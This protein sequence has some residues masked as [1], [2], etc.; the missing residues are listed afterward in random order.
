MLQRAFYQAGYHVVCLTSPTHPNFIASAST[1]GI[2]GHLL[3]DSRNLYQVMSLVWLELQQEEIEV[4]NFFLTGYSLGA[5][6]SAFVSHIDENRRVFNFKK[7]LMINPPVN[8]Y[9]SAL[10]L[11]AMLAK[12]L[13]GGM[14]NVQPF[15]DQVFH[16]FAEEYRQGD[17]VNF[18][19]DFLYAAYRKRQ[20]SDSILASLIGLTFRLSAA[21]VPPD[22]RPPMKFLAPWSLERVVDTPGHYVA[23]SCCTPFATVR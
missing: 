7:V 14:N 16:A 13:P 2:P 1:T 11:D 17:F 12:N 18:T 5:A 15:F 6:Q 4:T 3:D 20:P 21:D 10:I 8:L 22:V 9:T 23:A 19:G